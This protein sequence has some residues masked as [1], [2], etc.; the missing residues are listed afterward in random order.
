MQNSD[1]KDFS[2]VHELDKLFDDAVATGK[3][4][5]APSSGILPYGVYGI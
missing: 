3:Y 5:Y 1:I 4:N 2:F